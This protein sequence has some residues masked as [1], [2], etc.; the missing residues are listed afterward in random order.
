MTSKFSSKE[1]LKFGRETAKNNLWFFMALFAAIFL[2]YLGLGR[3]AALT[4]KNALASALV[5]LVN[6]VLQILISIGLISIPLKFINGQKAAFGDL[7]AGGRWFLR[8]F[9]ASV[10]YMLIILGGLALLIIPGLIWA[11]RFQFFGYLIVDRNLGAVEALKRSWAI[12][13]GA[14]WDLA[15]FSVLLMLINMLGLLALGVGLL[16]TAPIS[17]LAIAFV[18]RKLLSA[19]NAPVPAPAPASAIA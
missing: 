13:R 10:F 12:T 6:W 17:L 14:T 19:M 11:I 16:I 7:V 9:T 18:Y 8:Y 3:L 2:I 4:E 1:A 5:S 15:I